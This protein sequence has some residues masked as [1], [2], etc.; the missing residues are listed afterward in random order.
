MLHSALQLGLFFKGIGVDMQDALAL[1]QAEFMQGGQTAEAFEK[2]YS[3]NFRHQY[4]QA[5][6]HKNYQPHACGKVIGASLDPSGATGCP[7]RTCQAA[8]LASM[9]RGMKVADATATAAVALAQER[10]YQL[11]CSEVFENLHGKKLHVA[12]PHQFFAE[13]R[14][15]YMQR[16]AETKEG[17]GNRVD[18]FTP[19]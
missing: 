7:F 8:E 5:G 9:L 1:W 18:R 11:A 16:E 19:I 6:S 17:D 10:H 14:K 12:A 4:G 2:Q 13:S 15:H 3:Y